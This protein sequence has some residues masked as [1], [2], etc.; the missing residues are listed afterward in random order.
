[1]AGS[2]FPAVHDPKQSGYGG[3]CPVP[4]VCPLCSNGKQVTE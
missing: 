1:M 3:G 2:F 4:E